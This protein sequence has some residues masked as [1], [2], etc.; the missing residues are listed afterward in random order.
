LFSPDANISLTTSIDIAVRDEN[1]VY[2]NEL[3]RWN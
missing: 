2:P 3:T 1:F